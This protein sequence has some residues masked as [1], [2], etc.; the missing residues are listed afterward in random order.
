M[1]P[2]EV[3]RAGRPVCAQIPPSE[4][5]HVRLLAAV[6]PCPGGVVLVDVGWP[7]ATWHPWHYVPGQLVEVT[8]GREWEIGG[9][10]LWAIPETGTMYTEPWRGWLAYA[11]RH[12]NEVA[13][14]AVI[15]RAARE[16]M[17]DLFRGA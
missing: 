5:D 1:E 4:D 12:P 13:D 7:E 16:A 10:K 11:A 6:V 8:Q 2:N 14:P 15:A 17:P 9:V 3:I